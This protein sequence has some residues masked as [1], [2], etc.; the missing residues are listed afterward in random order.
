VFEK[1]KL[2][3]ALLK[4]GSSLKQAGLKEASDWLAKHVVNSE[5]RRF[6]FKDI[7]QAKKREAPR[8]KESAGSKRKTKK[9][10]SGKKKKVKVKKEEDGSS[11]VDDVSQANTEDCSDAESEGAHCEVVSESNMTE[12]MGDE[13]S[14]EAEGQSENDCD[15]EDVSEEEEEFD[16]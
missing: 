16:D 2:D 5:D 8:K 7:E 4:V 3:N 11:D 10:P 12:D 14:D 6:S 15:E 9:E 1:E 13:E